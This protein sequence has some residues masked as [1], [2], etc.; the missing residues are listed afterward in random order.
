M[1]KR[2]LSI[3]SQIFLKEKVIVRNNALI[4]DHGLLPCREL[5]SGLVKIEMM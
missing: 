4:F 5:N 3:V 1:F 2:P